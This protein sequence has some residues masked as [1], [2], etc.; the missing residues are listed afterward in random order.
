MIQSLDVTGLSFC[1][2]RCFNGTRCAALGMRI[3]RGKEVVLACFRMLTC[4]L[5][6]WTGEIH[7]VSLSLGSFQVENRIQDISN[8]KENVRNSTAPTN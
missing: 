8:K 2:R 4:N 3:V 6:G 7:K 5:S 1:F